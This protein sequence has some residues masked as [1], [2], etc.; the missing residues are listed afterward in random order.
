MS[1]W[2]YREFSLK[3]REFYAKVLE[4]SEK[5]ELMHPEPPPTPHMKIFRKPYGDASEQPARPAMLDT[6]V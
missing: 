2:V 1:S 6:E 4:E 5:S 3:V